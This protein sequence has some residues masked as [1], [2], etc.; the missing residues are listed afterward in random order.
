MLWGFL[1]FS[2]IGQFQFS[3]E[4]IFHTCGREL[5]EILYLFNLYSLQYFTA[6]R[7]L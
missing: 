6:F 3:L 1:P 7:N 2:S 5:L 4:Y